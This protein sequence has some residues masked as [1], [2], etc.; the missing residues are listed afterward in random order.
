MVPAV[1]ENQL[2]PAAARRPCQSIT[3]EAW[4]EGCHG[5]QTLCRE[6]LR[7][8]PGCREAWVWR[9]EKRGMIYG[10][11]LGSIFVALAFQPV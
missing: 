8:C 5:S 9:A 7:L 4:R 1:P 2:F 6:S 3:S 10:K 11:R